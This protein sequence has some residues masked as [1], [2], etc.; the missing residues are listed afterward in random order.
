MGCRKPIIRTSRHIIAEAIRVNEGVELK[1]ALNR[2]FLLSGEFLTCL[3]EV[4]ISLQSG[5]FQRYCSLD[6]LLRQLSHL[7]FSLFSLTLDRPGTPIR[8]ENGEPKCR[9]VHPD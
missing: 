2:L 3:K 8:Q 7:V 6:G 4:A 9:E 5:Q 1:A